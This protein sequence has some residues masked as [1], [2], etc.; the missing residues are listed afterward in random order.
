MLRK[1]LPSSKL[2]YRHSKLQEQ[3]NALEMFAAF[4]SKWEHLLQE[5]KCNSAVVLNTAYIDPECQAEIEEQLKFPSIEEF[6]RQ[7]LG[8]KEVEPEMEEP[9]QETPNQQSKEHHEP[10]QHE[11]IE[12][13]GLGAS[14]DF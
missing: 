9:T 8:S 4:L 5:M 10:N 2:E 11:H 14:F 7:V 1:F 12:D 13:G 6:D 3:H